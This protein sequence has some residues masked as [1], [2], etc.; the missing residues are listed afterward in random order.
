MNIAK[1]VIAVVAAAAIGQPVIS[2][3]TGGEDEAIHGQAS[4]MMQKMHTRMQSTQKQ[5]EKIHATEDADERHRLM[6]EH[7]QSMRDAMMMMHEME[8]AN[9]PELRSSAIGQHRQE[10]Q[11]KQDDTQCERIRE[12]EA[13]HHHMQ[14][15]MQMMQMMMQQ[16]VEQLAEH[17]AVQDESKE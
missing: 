17:Q 12:M 6:H 3:E 14:Q 10:L 9:R 8:N 13:G 15:R 16:M 2:E 5:M 4:P 1:V 7:M 11:C